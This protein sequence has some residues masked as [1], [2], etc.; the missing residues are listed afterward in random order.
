MK[1]IAFTLLVFSLAALL[2]LEKGWLQRPTV[3]EPAAMPAAVRKEGKGIRII[4]EGRIAAYPNAEITLSSELPAVIVRLPVKEKDHVHKGDLIAELKAEDM[5][6]Q[7]EEA[8]A[9]IA[10]TE[11]G[12]RLL[13][14][15]IE[16]TAK[17]WES[18]Q[19]SRQELERYQSQ[20]EVQRAQREARI[21]DA[22]RLQAILAKTQ[23]TSPI[24]GVVTSRNTD[25]GEMIAAGAP[26]VT[27]TDLG[28]LRIEAE[29]DEFDAGRIKLGDAVTVTA[30]GFPGKALKAIVEEIPDTV[31]GRRL[32][33]LDPSRPIDTRVLLVKIAF[34][35]PTP[36]KL[37]QRV[38]L[39]IFIGDR[40]N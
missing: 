14:L 40:P 1:S 35:E 25:P 2:A 29:V 37:G 11:A 22:H 26:I 27:V 36:F 24:D 15:E 34:K 30:E 33:P 16:R 32:K 31:V 10:E 28:R 8:K 19:A 17:L 18:R 38:D 3:A 9:R 7:G 20:R 4:A 23:V 39:E 12:I 13:D 5:K 6:A 21:A